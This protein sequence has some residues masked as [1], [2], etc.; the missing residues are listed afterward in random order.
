MKYF[1]QNLL[2]ENE[3]IFEDSFLKI[4]KRYFDYLQQKIEEKKI[5]RKA[6]SKNILFSQDPRKG[7]N[8]YI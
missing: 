1:Y 5:N 6:F 4:E 2:A 7:F 8:Y 3:I